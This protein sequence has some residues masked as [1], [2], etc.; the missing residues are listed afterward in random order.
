MKKTDRILVIHGPNL[1]ML[2]KR[3]PGIYGTR[4][5]EDINSR[6]AERAKVHGFDVEFYQSNHEGV[7]VDTIQQA[8]GCY[9]CLIIN[10]AALTHYSIAI[11]DAI[12]AV[13]IP[14]IEVHLSNIYR[15]EEFRHHSVI[16][17][18]VSGTICGFGLHSYILAIDAAA[19][20][21]GGDAL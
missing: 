7:I 2:G 18:V 5:L 9:D 15:R 10:A 20:I 11:R 19:E 3:E 1:N 17:A 4:T 16:S 14:T 13:S 12:S 8:A 21:I 6:I